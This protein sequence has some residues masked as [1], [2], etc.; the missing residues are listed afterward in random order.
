MWPE[1]KGCASPVGAKEGWG[2][3]KMGA[4]GIITCSRCLFL[5]RLVAHDLQ[6]LFLPLTF[7][8]LLLKEGNLL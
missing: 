3:K 5:Y 6:T 8:A 2:L 7:I 1:L 4:S